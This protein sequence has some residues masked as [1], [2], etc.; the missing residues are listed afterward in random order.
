VHA[1]LSNHFYHFIVKY[2]KDILNVLPAKNLL[3][4][5]G[6]PTTPH[7]KAFRVKPKIRDFR[8]FGCPASFKWYSA[9]SRQTQTQQATRA[10]FI[11]FPNNQAG[12]LFYTE[13]QIGSAHIHVSRDATFNE[14]FD[15]ALVFDTHPFQ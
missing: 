10:I 11:R 8:V 2:P 1:H 7:F 6:N 13:Q 15:S 12:W 5:N 4:H 3:D 14:N 9:T